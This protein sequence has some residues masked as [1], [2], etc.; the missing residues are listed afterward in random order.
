MIETLYTWGKNLPVVGY[1]IKMAYISYR[2]KNAVTKY[3]D[4]KLDPKT[5]K[6]V[7][8]ELEKEL[9]DQ[10]KDFYKAEIEPLVIANGISEETAKPIKE[11][12]IKEMVRIVTEKILANISSEDKQAKKDNKAEKGDS[13]SDKKDEKKSENS[14]EKPKKKK[15]ETTENSEEKPKKKKSETTENSEEKPKTEENNS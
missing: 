11:T 9:I 6:L 4:N 1:W 3:S 10:A 12:A 13:E 14:E 7:G 5:S 2:V 15:S 8:K